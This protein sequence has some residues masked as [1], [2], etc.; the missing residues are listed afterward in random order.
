[1]RGR[2]PPPSVHRVALARAKKQAELE[3]HGPS[4]DEASPRPSLGVTEDN[5][6]LPE[7][8]MDGASIDTKPLTDLGQ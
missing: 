1:M 3:Q 2:L 8:G 4:D 5:S 6:A 7:P